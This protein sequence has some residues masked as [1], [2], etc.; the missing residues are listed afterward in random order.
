[1]PVIYNEDNSKYYWRMSKE[2]Q[3]ENI[4][5]WFVKALDEYINDGIYRGSSVFM[6]ILE[7]DLFKTLGCVDM[8]IR[9]ELKNIVDLIY[10]DCPSDCWGSDENIK[11]W[12]EKHGFNV[13]NRV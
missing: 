7:S 13:N 5:E 10:N 12:I 1:M 8:E 3:Y 6:V 11:Y 2:E 4:P 9:K